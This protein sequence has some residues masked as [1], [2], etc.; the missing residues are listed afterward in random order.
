MQNSGSENETPVPLRTIVLYNLAGFS[1]N[2]YDTILYAWIPYFL[3]LT[4]PW[5]WWMIGTGMIKTCRLS[6]AQAVLVIGLSIGIIVCA[7]QFVLPMTLS[8]PV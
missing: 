8:K 5:K 6:F 1:F 4:E 3:I 2:I 7:F